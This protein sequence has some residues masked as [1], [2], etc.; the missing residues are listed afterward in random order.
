MW[1]TRMLAGVG[2]LAIGLGG[3]WAGTASAQTNTATTRDCSLLLPA[4]PPIFGGLDPDFM[5]LSGANVGPSGTLTVP[6]NL[7]SLLLKASESPDAADQGNHVTASATVT[8]SAGA[9]TTVTGSGTGSV[10]LT[11]PLIGASS[12]TIS[13]SATFDNGAHACPG[14]LTPA[15]L[16]PSPFV[17]QVS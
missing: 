7:Q 11:L 1:T 9:A 13:W 8:P 3:L 15:N 2:T 4:I 5:E 16:N 12:Y 17:V 6:A 10:A 14:L